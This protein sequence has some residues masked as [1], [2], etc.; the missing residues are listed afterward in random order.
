MEPH[1]QKTMRTLAPARFGLL[2]GLSWYEIPAWCPENAH[3]WISMVRRFC[4]S[5][6]LLL[7][8]TYSWMINMMSSASY[9]P[10]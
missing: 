7:N 3:N 5:A 6:L 9:F 2:T 4:M 1:P 8:S 10:W